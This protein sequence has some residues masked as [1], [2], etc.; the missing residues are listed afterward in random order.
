MKRREF[1]SLVGGTA[2]A[3]PLAGNAQ[4]NQIWRVGVLMTNTEKDPEP[5]A[6]ISAFEAGA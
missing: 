5:Q 4:Q 1:I 6:W 2:I 3:W